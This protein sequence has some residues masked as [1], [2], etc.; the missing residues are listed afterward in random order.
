MCEGRVAAIQGIEDSPLEYCPDCGLE[1]R[2][3]ISSVSFSIS[4]S[5]VLDKSGSRGFT[6]WKKVESGK[7][8]KVSGPG[9]DMVV[10]DP[11]DIQ[12]IKE[13]ATPAK[14]LDLDSKNE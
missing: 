12:A 5:S 1:V 14:R 6:T 8:E 4:K 3:V 10:G 2:R 11:R 7:W 9:A 13:E